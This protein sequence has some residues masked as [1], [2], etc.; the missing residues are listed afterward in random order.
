MDEGPI[1]ERIGARF[2]ENKLATLP[3]LVHHVI[4]PATTAPIS[5]RQIHKAPILFIINKHGQIME[6]KTKNGDCRE[7]KWT[8][9]LQD[10]GG[11]QQYFSKKGKAPGTALPSLALRSSRHLARPAGGNISTSRISRALQLERSQR[12]AS[13][14][15]RSLNRRSPCLR[16]SIA[17]RPLPPFAPT[18][19]SRSAWHRHRHRHRPSHPCPPPRHSHPPHHRPQHCSG[20]HNPP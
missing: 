11:R 14:A 4:A 20:T 6:S 2:R 3:C 9:S 7:M 10:V 19:S 16:P 5:H 12:R 8:I 1:V 15:A 18:S 13:H 17:T